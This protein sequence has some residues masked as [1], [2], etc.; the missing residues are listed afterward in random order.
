MNPILSNLRNI[1]L[2]YAVWLM[3]GCLLAALLVLTNISAWTNA[4]LFAVPVTL[5]FGSVSASAYYVA[6][7]LP[8]KKRSFFVVSGVFGGT[9]LIYGVVWVVLCFMWNKVSLLFEESW[10][11]ITISQ[12]LASLLLIC[13]TLL[14]LLSI[15][16][17]DVLLALDNIRQAERREAASE[18]LARDAELQVLRTQINPHFLFNSLNSISALTAIDAA[19]ARNMTIELAQFFRQTLALSEKQKISLS[20]EI[21]LCNHFL[22]IEKIRFGKKLQV[23]MDIDPDSE[24]CL[25]PPMLLQPLLENAIKHGIRDLIDGGTIIVSSKA[26]DPWLFVAIDN[27]VDI[28]PSQTQG[29]GTGLKNLQARLRTLYADKARAEWRIAEQ[30]FRIE[31]ALPL[32]RQ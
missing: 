7:S 10:A 20:E 31:I 22:A 3:I 24:N 8:M 5:V 9:A 4:L 29:T 14:Y 11:G 21:A 18:V 27:P 15:L 23:Q 13:G 32:E 19:A 28:Q 25:L 12:H 6:R 30:V 26:R 1:T 2:T 17:Y 16:V